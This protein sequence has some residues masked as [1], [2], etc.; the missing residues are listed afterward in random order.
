LMIVSNHCA[1]YCRFCTRKRRVGDPKRSPSKDCILQQIEYV[2]RHSEVRDVLLSGGDP[3]LL[4]DERL[5]FILGKLRGIPHIEIIRIGT[6]VPCAFPERVTEKLCKMLRQHHP[7]FI[8]IHFN[9]PREVNEESARACGLL[10]D[11][12]IPLGSQTVLLRG[13]ND[14]AEV[15]KNLMQKLLTIRVRP[16][17]LFQCDPVK[18]TYHFRTR[19]EEGLEI[20][21]AIIGYTSGLAVPH[22]VIDAPG[23]GGK[24]P[25]VPNYLQLIEEDRVLLTNYQGR[26]FEYPQPC[27]N[28]GVSLR[29]G[30]SQILN[31]DVSKPRAVP[32]VKA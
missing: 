30:S 1:T 6:R 17:Y 4:T 20:M 9:H 12:G 7:I 11:A 8:N 22:Y 2:R 10:A 13:V 31:G 21:K 18:G 27:I 16:Y 19:V 25:L 15:M 29:V 5:E 26:S 32:R 24:I 28:N 23:G 14:K 3:F